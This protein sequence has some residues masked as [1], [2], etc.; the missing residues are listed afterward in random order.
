MTG[1]SKEAC[2]K[3]GHK[4]LLLL[5]SHESMRVRLTLNTS[6]GSGFL[7]HASGKI[8]WKECLHTPRW[9]PEGHIAAFLR[10]G[11]VIPVPKN[12]LRHS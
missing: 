12:F 2:L 4:K 11:L 3:T 9:R 1:Q 7:I 6:V 10:Q 5:L 8:H